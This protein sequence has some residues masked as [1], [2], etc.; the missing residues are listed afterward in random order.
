MVISQHDQWRN[1]SNRYSH[2]RRID[3]CKTTSRS[4]VIL[5]HCQTPISSKRL[6]RHPR[7]NSGKTTSRCLIVILHGE[8]PNPSQR[9]PHRHLNHL[10]KLSL[11]VI[12]IL[13]HRVSSHP[14]ALR[15][16]IWITTAEQLRDRWPTSSTPSS[17]PHPTLPTSDIWIARHNLSPRWMFILQ[18]YHLTS[19]TTFPR[20][21]LAL[22]IASSFR[23]E[24]YCI[25]TPPSST[26][27]LKLNLLG[28]H[29]LSSLPFVTA[30]LSIILAALSLCWLGLWHSYMRI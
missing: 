9:L 23:T 11:R 1:S 13:L 29:K 3:S 26:L 5:L 16:N 30:I 14:N 27:Q 28:N 6:P 19:H 10:R 21:D 17:S 4:V 22:V 15:I 8:R 7:M 25:R 12:V 20:N 18:Q 2:S 24:Q